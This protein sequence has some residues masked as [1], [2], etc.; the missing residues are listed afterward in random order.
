[1]PGGSGVYF[2][3][4]YDLLYDSKSSLYRDPIVLRVGFVF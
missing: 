3:A 2:M 4:L 1:M